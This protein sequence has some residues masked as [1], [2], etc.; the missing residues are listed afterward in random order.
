MVGNWR[1]YQIT[2]RGSLKA[3][4]IIPSSYLSLS[5]PPPSPARKTQKRGLQRRLF[6]TPEMHGTR[7]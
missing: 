5:T 7:S 4:G 1:F 3:L 2:D 6:G